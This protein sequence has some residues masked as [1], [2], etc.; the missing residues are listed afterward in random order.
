[1]STTDS[2]AMTPPPAPTRQLRRSRTDRIGA[3][4]AGGLGEYFGVDPVLFRVLFATAAFFGGAGVLAYLLAWAAIPEQ[5]AE[6]AAVDGWIASLR[7]HRVPFW[8]ILTGGAILFWLIAFSWWAPG[9]FLPVMAVVIILVVAFGRRSQPSLPPPAQTAPPTQPVSLSKDDATDSTDTPATT[10]AAPAWVNDTRAWMR[11]AR[12]ARRERLRRALPVKV[13]TLVTFVVTMVVLGLIDAAHGIVLPTY[14]WFATG[15]LGTGLLVGLATRRA[16]WSVALL[17]V[18]S[19][20]G[21]VAFAGTK[22]SLR[23]GIGDTQWR[24]TDTLNSS[25]DLAFGRAELDLRA[26]PDPTAPTDTEVNVA[27]GQVVVIAP[28]TMNVV[29]D[30]HVRFGNIAVDGQRF[31]EG[32]H[33]HGIG[34]NRTIVAPVNAS[35]PTVTI[36]VHLGEGRIDVRHSS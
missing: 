21:L 10:A 3:G 23:D 20:I 35:G 4:V 22:V 36:D 34:V 8:L 19:T 2:F 25:Y 5:G 6:R 13:A 18:A 32:F 9:P 27:A 14:F 15:I 1:M 16:S 26:L 7:A 12:E 28:K 17:L 31:Y 33:K 11:D 30:A 29:V 24:P